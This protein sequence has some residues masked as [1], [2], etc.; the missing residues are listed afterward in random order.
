M[1]APIWIP[2]A[3][4]IARANLTAFI[5][6]VRK[7]HPAAAVQD[8]A[9]LHAWS[10][11][12]PQAFW[13]E[14]WRFC[15]V[16]AAERPG[17]DPWDAVGVGLDRMAPPE[18]GR[19]PAWFPGA[20]LNFAENLLR[21]RDERIALAAWDERGPQRRWSYAALA[22]EVARIAGALRR[23]GVGPGDRVAGFLPN[24]P[25]AI[26]AMLATASLGAIWSSCS[27]DFGAK[28][29]LDRFSQIAP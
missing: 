27:P 11:R 22:D 26:I 19:G 25:E 15:G 8:F 18:P 21:F 12:E 7:R 5:A 23:L 16:I 13:A 10:I 29:V 24:I 4:D 2:T 14:V 6:A 28:G 17:R 20:R 1:T 9:T 3:A